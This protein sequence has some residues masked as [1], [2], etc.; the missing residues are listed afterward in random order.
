M[1]EKKR[2]VRN[3][4]SAS[5]FFSFRHTSSFSLQI[6]LVF[7]SFRIHACAAPN[8]NPLF[9]FKMH[10]IA[11]RSAIAPCAVARPTKAN[12]APAKPSTIKLQSSPIAA[13]P[14]VAA[15]LAAASDAPRGLA[16]LFTDSLQ[17]QADFF[18]TLGLPDWLVPW[19]HPGNMAGKR[20]R[21][22]QRKKSF[23]S[24]IFLALKRRRR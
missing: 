11:R 7:F 2:K 16:K 24:L 17:P 9:I 21:E 12:R 15:T 6:A 5:F 22:R 10:M 19:G 8:Q 23:L 1:K 3:L 4:R 13:A 14:V 20:Q 18:S